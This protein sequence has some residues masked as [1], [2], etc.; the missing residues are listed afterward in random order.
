M[1]AYVHIL[2]FLICGSCSPES[3]EFV[4]FVDDQ[5]S[6][7]DIKSLNELD[8]SN[9]LP[10]TA[11]KKKFIRMTKNEEKVNGEFAKL[12]ISKKGDDSL[13]FNIEVFRIEKNDTLRTSN[14]GGRTIQKV[15]ASKIVKETLCKFLN[16]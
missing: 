6:G 10:E 13:S 3:V 11:M 8:C 15:D 2:L 14:Y 7:I 5:H 9:D 16:K 1:K 12:T 4:V